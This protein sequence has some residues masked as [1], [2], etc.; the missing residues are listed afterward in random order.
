VISYLS[1]CLHFDR[2]C[3]EESVMMFLLA[4][5]GVILSLLA[6]GCVRGEMQRPGDDSAFGVI[7]W[8]LIGVAGYSALA[9]AEAL[10]LEAVRPLAIVIALV[11]LWLVWKAYRMKMGCPVCPLVWV[12]N[13]LIVIAAFYPSAR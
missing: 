10:Y 8:A 9:A 2:Q 3:E 1:S 4:G 6:W 12:L 11:T 13:T 5:A 7:P